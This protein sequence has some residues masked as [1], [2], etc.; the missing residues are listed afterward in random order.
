M[1]SKTHKLSI[2][3][4]MNNIVKCYN[5]KVLLFEKDFFCNNINIFAVTFDS[6]NVSLLK[7]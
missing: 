6:F 4:V 3:R 2:L 5:L 7:Y 1:I